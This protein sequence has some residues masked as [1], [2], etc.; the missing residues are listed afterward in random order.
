[1]YSPLQSD[2]YTYVHLRV[3]PRERS[4]ISNSNACSTIDHE[5][6]QETALRRLSDVPILA[7]L[8]TQVRQEDGSREKYQRFFGE[9]DK[10]GS[11]TIE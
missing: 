5:V 7:D 9:M 8:P 4:E 1:M 2:S 11:K 10:D 3:E 6:N